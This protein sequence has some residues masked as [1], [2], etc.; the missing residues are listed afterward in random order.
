MNFLSIYPTAAVQSAV[1]DPGIIK[2]DAAVEFL[3][4]GTPF[5]HS[6]K[7]GANAMAET[8]APNNN[9]RAYIRR[10]D[11][12]F[13]HDGQAEQHNEQ[14]VPVQQQ[15]NYKF[16]KQEKCLCY[17][18][19]INDI[20]ALVSMRHLENTEKKSIFVAMDTI[21]PVQLSKYPKQ[22]PFR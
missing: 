18:N 13:L 11:V 21:L 14:A 22:L 3:Q 1:Y 17:S 20:F 12:E 2:F 6:C 7:P 16:S 19:R 15:A 9:I 10:V 8:I 4:N 5:S